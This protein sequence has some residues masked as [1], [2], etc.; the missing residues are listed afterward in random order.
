MKKILFRIWQ[1]PQPSETFILNQIITAIECGY[2]VKILV[3]DFLE[4][5]ASSQQNLFQHYN[6]REKIILEN[7]Q[8]PK[9][10]NIRVFKAAYLLITNALFF[11]KLKSY[12]NLKKDLSQIY[13]FYFFKK[14]RKFDLIHIQYGTNAKP[15]D[16]LKKNGLLKKKII[17]SFHGHDAFFPIN[18][19]IKDQSYYDELFNSADA[20]IANTPYLAET[21]IKLGCKNNSLRT[22]PV[23]VDTKFFTPSND[24]F[25]KKN[26]FKIINIGRLDRIKGQQYAIDVIE[27]LRNK[28]YPIELYIIGEGKERKKLENLIIQKGL[29]E[30]VFL[31]GVKDHLTIRKYLQKNN[32]YL[33]SSVAVADGR[34][35]TQGLA[36]LEAHSCGLPA[37]VF[38]SGGVKYTVQE[39]ISGFIVP[40][41]DTA[42]MANK[43]EI[44]INDPALRNHMAIAARKF[45]EQQYSLE[46][47]GAIWCKTYKELI[48]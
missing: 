35:E 34:R 43:I 10:I 3:G 46:K 6:I 28:N 13:R 48:E 4:I 8:I 42:S 20:V 2:E 44:L 25:I 18:G 11:F 1:F 19:M 7:Y 30:N 9:N 36:I 27:I 21:L 23:G 17:V 24:K 12:L 22:I 33:H 29:E 16:I 5:D 39:G 15:I 31:I 47:I 14:L 40:E 38:D 32:V 26:P 45:V 37:V 41:F